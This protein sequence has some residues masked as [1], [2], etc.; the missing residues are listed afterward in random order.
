MIGSRSRPSKG[1]GDAWAG[2]KSGWA[3]PC[4]DPS[5]DVRTVLPASL[6][7][8]LANRM[9]TERVQL[10]LHAREPA[11]TRAVRRMRQE[12]LIPGV[13]YGQGSEPKSFYVVEREFRAATAGGQRLNAIFQVAF[14]NGD[15]DLYA[16][17][18]DYQIH[19]TRAKLLHLDFQEIRLD[20]PIESAIPIEPVGSAP[21]VIEGGILNIVQR[22]V[23]IS[24]LPLELPDVIEISIEGMGLGDSRTVG[25]LE[26]PEGITILDD[27]EAI[28]LTVAL[29]RVTL[30]ETVEEEGLEGEELEEGD[31]EAV[32][33]EGES[34]DEAEV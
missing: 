18:K 30:V 11:G 21:G 33:G 17:V 19:P 32:D 5:A 3:S 7:A 8:T 1:A 6:L 24:G 16:V 14:D 15:N 22:E 28:V 2:A 10:E 9:T 26:A 31:E 12:G 13:I 34:E 20:Q 25:D 29:T 27:P 4:S 23:N